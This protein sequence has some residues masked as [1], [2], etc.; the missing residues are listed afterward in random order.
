MVT[1]HASFVGAWLRPRRPIADAGPIG[2][3]DRPSNTTLPFTTDIPVRSYLDYAFPLSIV[4]PDDRHRTRLLESFV[5]LFFPDDKLP[6][7]RVLMVPGLRTADWERFGLIE[8]E[9]IDSHSHR[10]R[11]PEALLD[12]LTRRLA[13][14]HYIEIHLDE[15]FLPRR[16]CHERM[17]SV[18]DNMLIGYDLTARTFQLAGYSTDYELYPVPWNDVLQAFYHMP[19]AQLGRRMIRAI[20]RRAGP[21][22]GFDVRGMA[23]Q[24]ADYVESRQTFTP[25]QLRRARLYRMARRFTGAWGMHTYEAFRAWLRRQ[26]DAR[27]VLD[28]RATRTLWEHKACM[29]QRL[30]HLERERLVTAGAGYARAYAEVERLARAVRF[31]A[32][33]YNAAG[34]KPSHVD[35][36][37]DRLTTMERLERTILRDVVSVLPRTS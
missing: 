18:H 12:L 16:P 32:Y 17:H 37:S 24:L 36:M 28:L 14:G 21:P 27:E 19:R 35:A 23:A 4:A 34:L 5:Q 29:L 13:R 2:A 10:L 8:T 31:E 15:F 26:G 25:R 22:A 6:Y 7:D 20:W 11:R 33:E 30:A 1:T 9:T 3:D